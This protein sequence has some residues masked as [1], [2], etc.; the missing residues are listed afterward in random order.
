MES[1]TRHVA[2]SVAVLL[3]AGLLAW[4][5]LTTNSPESRHQVKLGLDLADLTWPVVRSLYIAL[6][7]AQSQRTRKEL[8]RP[9]V[10]SL[11]D[12]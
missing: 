8:F 4:F 7:R 10:K 5:V 3:V 6:T 1:R 9:C 12:A 11:S 2:W